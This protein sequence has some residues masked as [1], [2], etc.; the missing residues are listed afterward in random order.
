MGLMKSIE[1]FKP[2][3][4]C[5]LATYAYWWIRQTVRKA[6]FQNS[7]TIRLPENVY[8]LLSKVMEAKRSYIQE[9]HHHP[10]KEQEAKR[11]G[12]SVHKLEKLAST[13][14]PPLSLQQPLWADQDTTFQEIIADTGV[15]IPD[16]SVSK[17]LMRRD[18]RN[19][20]STLSP[21]ERQIMKLRYGIDGGEQGSLSDIGNIFGLSKERVRQLES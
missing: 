6:I 12:I 3:A 11:A 19:L 15:E 10:S 17:Q 14:T 4:G 5:Q 9:G 20:L 13:T 16:L 2:Q 21:R 8:A 7:R 1:K 18:V